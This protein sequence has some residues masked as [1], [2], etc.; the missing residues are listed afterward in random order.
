MRKKGAVV[1]EDPLR[2]LRP[3]VV[4]SKTFPFGFHSVS[5]LFH[6]QYD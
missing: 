1:F 4:R 5:I 2:G 3:R 6:F